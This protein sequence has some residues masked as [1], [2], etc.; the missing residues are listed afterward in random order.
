[1]AEDS[2][3]DTPEVDMQRVICVYTYMKTK[4]MTYQFDI[5]FCGEASCDK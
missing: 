5:K 1:M 2:C 3:K 4:C